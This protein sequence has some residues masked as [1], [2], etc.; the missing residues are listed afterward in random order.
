MDVDVPQGPPQGSPPL[1]EVDP[2]HRAPT[3][4]ALEINLSARVVKLLERLGVITSS[5]TP[6][7]DSPATK[8][9]ITDA[10]STT[11]WTPLI[12]LSDLVLL[13]SCIPAARLPAELP[14][15]IESASPTPATRSAL[16]DTLARLAL[17]PALMIE[18][19]TLFRPVAVVLV[20][21]WVEL[22]G[23]SEEGKW[24]EGEPGVEKAPGEKDAVEKVWIALVRA[25][26][27]MHDEVMPYL[28]LI[29][30]HPLLLPGPPL[31]ASTS[32]SFLPLLLTLHSAIYHLPSLPSVSEWSLPQAAEEVMKSHPHRGTR[33]VAWRI[34]RAW[35]GLYAGTGEELKKQWVW[36]LPVAS[37]SNADEEVLPFAPVVPYDSDYTTEYT[38]IFGPDAASPNDEADLL[39]SGSYSAELVSGTRTDDETVPTSRLVDGGLEV[40]VR[41]R[42]VDPWV[43]PMLEPVRA[44]E[45]R[46]RAAL[47]SNE[48]SSSFSAEGE[49]S[50]V[51][52]LPLGAL[53]EPAEFG[54]TVV[55]VA[56]AL[57]FRE[58]LIPSY[59]SASLAGAPSPV[60]SI[61]S[62]HAAAPSSTQATGP[63][64]EMFV[65]TSSHSALLA[66]LAGNVRRRVPTLVTGGPSSGKQSAV[67]HLWT[68]VHTAPS[69]TAL[70][71]EAKK[72]GLVVINLADRSLDSKSLLGSLSSAPSSSTSASTGSGAGQFTFIEGPLTRAV[73]QGR[74]LLL[75]NIDQAA[76]ELLSVVKVVAERMY[77]SAMQAKEGKSYG[78]I[79]AQ[80]ADG[81]VGVRVGGGEGRWVSA[82]EGFMLFATRSVPISSLPSTAEEEAPPATFFASH[83]FAPVLLPALS[84][85]EVAQIVQGRYGPQLDRVGGLSEL[86]VKSWEE[87]RD[88]NAQHKDGGKGG[89]KRDVGVRDLLRWCRRVAHLLPP[90]LALPSLASNPTL[91]EEVFVEARDVFLGSMVLPPAVSTPAITSVEDAA[92]ALSTDR[93]P[94]DRFSVLARSLA[95]SLGLSSERAEWCLRRRVP[96]LVLPTIDTSSGVAPSPSANLSVKVG[97]VSL[98]YLAPSTHSS[99]SRPYALTKPSLLAL[100]KLAVCLSLSEPV[101]LVGETGTGKTAAV[102]YLAELMGKKL[103]ALNLS[104]QTEAGDLVGG[105]RPIDEAEEARRSASEIVNRFVELFGA[106][107]SLS[108][109]GEFVSHV[110]KAFDKK[111]Y[112]RLV[113]LWR[114]AARMAS[115]RVSNDAPVTDAAEGDEQAQRKRRKVDSAKAALAER[116]KDFTTVVGDFEHRHVHAGGK[117]KAKF[118][119]SF[120]EGP[121]AQ[122][123]RNG[124]WVLLDEVNLASSETLESLSTLLQAPN[125]S[126]VL[127]EQGDLEPIP[128]HPEFRLFACMNPATDVGK[129]DLP[130][131]LRAKFSEIWVPPPDEDRDALRT[132]VEG[133][134]GRVAVSDRKVVDDV[135]TLYAVVKDLALRAQLADGQNMPPHFS[136]RTL[137]RALSFAS[138]FAP[139]FGLRR[140]LYEGFVMAFTML[141]D[142]RS[143]QVVRALIDKHVVQP[144]KNPRS[145]MERVPAM[146]SGME[147]AI[148]IHHYWLEEGPHDPEEP[149]DYILTS[150]VQ[151]KVCDLARAV[152]T[153]KVPVLIQGPTS[154]GKTSV[155]EYLAKRTGHRFVRINNHEHTDIQEY[156]GTYVSDPHSG[157]LVFQEGVLVR[158]LRRGDWIVLDELN[159]APTDVLEALNRLLDDNR[160]LVIPETGEVV[161][162]HPHF[163]LFATQNPPG[164]YGGRK[165]LSRAFRNRFLEMHF[166]DVPKDELKT[167]LERRCR[168]APSHAEKTVNVFLEL[169]RRRQAGRVFEQKQ[170]FAT[171]RDLFRW[172]GRGP[173]ETIQQL[174]EDGYMLLAER[175]RRADDKQTVKDVLEEVLKVKLDEKK[176]YDFERLPQLGLPVPSQ[177]AELVW[178]SAM[179]RL[180]FLIAAS[181]QRNEPVLLVGETGAGKTSVCQALALA[182]SSQ[183]HIVG[184]HQNTETADLLGGQRPLR[185]RAALQAALRKNAVELLEQQGRPTPLEEADIEDVLALIEALATEEKDEAAKTLAERIR[186]TTALFEWHDGPLV[187]AMRGGDLILLDEISLADD[188]V[189]ERLNSVLE[190]SRTLVL[191]EK[192]GHD[193][194]DIRVVGQE[195]FQILATMNP[196]GDFGKKELSPALRNRFTEIWVPAVDDLDD[197]LHIIGSRWAKAQREQ[198]EPFG[199]KILDFAKWL[200]QQ[201]GQGDG[202]GIGLRDILGWVDFLNVA[203]K[204]QGA[205][206]LVMADSFCQGA[207]MTVV[208]GL[209]ALPATSGLSKDGLDK[210]KSSCWRYLEQLVPTTM[211]PESLPLDVN[212]SEGVFSVGPF[213]VKKGDIPPAKVDYT[214]LAPTTRL[215]AMRLL[216]ALQLSKP[217]LL[218]GSPGVGKTSLVTALSAATGHSLV[219]INLSDQTDLMDL[220][221]SDLPVE[222]GKSGEFAWKDA[223]FLAAMQKGEWV[224]LD[225]M[226]LASQSVLEGLNSCLDHR[227]AVYIPELDRTFNRHPDFRIFAAQN[228]LGQGGGR[229]GLPKSFLD[230]FSLVHMEELDAIDLNAIAAALYPDMDAAILSKMIAFNSTVHRQTMEQRAFGMEGSP[231]EFNLRDVLRWLTLVRSSSGLDTRQ[232]EAIEYIRLLYLQRFRDSADREHVA[233]L[234]ASS[235]GE[236]VDPVERPWP[237]L[238]SSHAQ[239]GHSL[240]PRAD[241]SLSSQR[242]SASLSLQQHSLQPLEALTKCLDMGWL[243]ILTGPR[244]T[245]KTA[246]IRQVAALGGR[247]LREFTMNA[248]VDTL[249]LLGSFEQADRF[250]ELDSLAGDAVTLLE[251][252]AAGQLRVDGSSTVHAQLDG[253]RRIRSRITAEAAELEVAA[254]GQAIRH[255]FEAIPAVDS[256]R[257]D[258]LSAKIDIAVS[259]ADAATG[260]ARFEWVDGPLVQAMKNG[261]WLLIEDANL[262]SPSVL[263]RLNSLFETGGRLQLAERGPVN[264]EIQIIAPHPD[265]RLV[266]TLDPR[267]GEL[268]RAMRNRG[269]EIAVLSPPS[270][271]AGPGFSADEFRDPTFSPLARL[272]HL[273]SL[274]ASAVSPAA[275]VQQIG[276]TLSPSHFP[277]ALRVLRTF[278][279]ADSTSTEYVLRQLGQHA[280]VGHSIGAKKALAQT[281]EVPLNLLTVQPL[282][283]SLV[284]LAAALERNVAAPLSQA[285]SSLLETLTFLLLS[286]TS[287]PRG[288][289]RSAAKPVRHLA[290]WDRSLLAAHGK[291]KLEEVESV[292]AG[293]FPL[294]TALGGLVGRLAGFQLDELEES[295][296]LALTRSAKSL[297]TLARELEAVSDSADLDFSTVQHV[298]AWVEEA[299]RQLPPACA[300]VAEEAQQRLAPLRSSLTLTSGKA[301]E[302][303]WKAS[304]PY[305]HSNPAL[306]EVYT[307]L[308]ERGR[309]SVG[310]RWENALSNLFLEISV[311]LGVPQVAQ[312]QL[313]NAA[314]HIVEQLLERIPPSDPSDSDDSVIALADG[315]N[316]A[317]LLVAE[318]A[319]VSTALLGRSAI[320]PAG[321]L[322]KIVQGSGVIPLADA[323]ALHQLA[324]WPDKNLDSKPAAVFATLLHWAEHLA[325]GAAKAP[326]ATFPIDIVRPMLLKKVVELRSGETPTLG[327]LVTQSRALARTAALQLAAS[328]TDS[329]SRVEG[330][331][332]ALVALIGLVVGSAG[333]DEEPLSTNN[334]VEAV[335]ARAASVASLSEAHERYLAK[336][337][338][339]LQ[340]KQVPLPAVASGLVAFARFLWHLY[341]P[342]LP[343]DPAV[344][345]RAHSGFLAR[346][347][348]AMSEV[349]AAVQLD[350]RALTGNSSNAKLGRVQHEVD[351]LRKQLEQAGVAPVVREGNPALLNALFAELRSFQEQIV[352]DVQLDSL[353]KAFE[354]PWSQA[355]ASREANLQ[356][357]IDTLLRRLDVAYNESTDI[358]API[359][360][361][362]ALFKI[363][364]ALLTHVAQVAAAPAS[365][366]AFRTLARRL[367]GFPSIAYLPAVHED[368]LPLTIKV[369]E[370]PLHPAQATLLQVAALTSS[371]ADETLSTARSAVRLTQLYERLHYLY[372]TDRRH[373][374]EAAEAAAS[375]YKAKVDVQQVATDE[376]LEAA[377]FAK[378]FPSFEGDAADKEDDPMGAHAS[379]KARLVQ[380]SDQHLLAKLHVGL[381]GERNTGFA[382]QASA[383][384]KRLRESGVA[385]LLPRLYESLD[386]S[387]D[388]DSAAFRVRALVELSQ[389]VNPPEQVEA[390]HHDFYNEPNVRETA[391]AVPVLLGFIDRLTDLVAKWPDQV[392]LHSL[393]DRC[394]AILALTADAS[395]ALVLTNLEQ[396]LQQSEDWEKYA[397][398]E[399]S[400]STNRNALIALIVEWR[401]FELTCWSRLLTTVEVKF[402]ESAADWWFRFYEAAIRGAPGVDREA[403]AAEDPEAFYRDL[404]TLLDSFITSSSVGQFATRLDLVVSFAN[405]AATLGGRPDAEEELGAGAASLKRVAALLYN[406]HAFYSQF[407]TR[408]STF[409]TS[410][411][412]RVE[413]EVQNVIKLASWKDVNVFALRASAVRSHHQLYK[414]V[415]KLRTLLQKPASDQFS[416]DNVEKISASTP[417][418]LPPFLTAS[419]DLPPLPATVDTANDASHLVKLDQTLSRLNK[420]AASTVGDLVGAGH[421]AG[422]EEFAVQI[423]ST[424]KDLREE[425]LGAEEGREQRVKNLI[426]R[427]RRAWRDLLNELKR[428]GISPS[429][430]PK[431]V[432][433]LEDVGAVYSLSPSAPLLSLDE[434]VFGGDSRQRVVKADSYHYRMLSE[435]PTLRGYPAAHNADVRT[436]DVQRA[437]GHINSGINY[438]FDQRAQLLAASMAQVQLDLFVKRFEAVKAEQPAL[439]IRQL[440][441]VLL[442]TVSEVVQALIETRDELV[443]FR[444]ATQDSIGLEATLASNTVI[445]SL[446]TLSRDQD[447][448][449]DAVAS[450]AY[451]DPVLAMPE[452]FTFAQQTRQHLL[453]TV[454][455]FTDL[456]VPPSLRY[457]LVPL[458]NYLTD[459]DIPSLGGSASSKQDVQS[460]KAAHDDLVSAVLIVAQELKKLADEGVKVVEE[461]ELVDGAVGVAGKS[462]RGVL[463]AFRL[464]EMLAKVA[465]FARRAHASLAQGSTAVTLVTRVAPFLRLYSELFS[466]HLSSFFDWHKSSLKLNH[467]LASILK[468][469]AAEGFCR[470]PEGDT[471]N[472]ADADTSDGKT[473]EGTGMAEGTGAKNVSNE[474]EDE[475]QLEGLQS[476][477]PQEKREDEQQEEGDDDAVEMQQD[478]D[479]EMEDRG[480]GAKDEQDEGESDDEDEEKEDPEEQVADVDPLDPS[481]VD[482][483]FWGDD[484]PPQ[485]NKEGQTDEVNQETTKSAGEAEMSAKEDQQAAPQ[486]KGEEGAE[487]EK[488][489]EQAGKEE[490]KGQEGAEK[491]E[492]EEQDGEAGEE[493]GGEGVEQGEEEENGDDG[494]Q[495]PPQTGEQLDS[496]MPEGENLDL[497]DDMNLDGDEKDKDADGDEDLDL[498]DEMDMPEDGPEGEG[499]DD[500]R[501]D[502]VDEMGDAKE[503]GAEE[504]EE[505]PLA[506]NDTSAQPEGEDEEDTKAEDALDQ[507]FGGADQGETGGEGE[508]DSAASKPDSASAA[509]VSRQA[510]AQTAAQETSEPNAQ[511]EAG[512]EDVDAEME[513]DQ[514]DNLA[515][516]APSAT[517]T[518]PSKQRA[519]ADPSADP[520]AQPQPQQDRS[521]AEPQRSLGDALQNWRRRLEAIGDLAQPEDKPEGAAPEPQQD[522]AVEYV[523]EGDEQDVDEQALGPAS[524]E[525]VKKLEQLHIGEEVAPPEDFPQDQEMDAADQPDQPAQQQAQTMQLK[526][527][528]LTEADAKA[529]PA[530]ELRQDRSIAEE[531]REMEDEVRAEDDQHASTTFAPPIDPQED[532]AVEQALLK[533]RA[534]DDPNM[535]SEGVW[536]LYESLTR[537]LSFALTEQLRLILEPTL[538]TRLKGDY[539]SGKRLN[540]KKIIPYI[541]SEFTKDKIWLRR[542]RPSQREYQ[543]LIAIDDSKSM[544]DSHSVHLAFQSLALISRALTRL[545]VGGVSICRFGESMD[546]LHPFEAG[547]VS[548]EAGANLLSKFT[549]QQT[550][551]DVR[552]LVERSLAHLAA[553]KESAASGKSSLSAGDLWQLQVIISDG[554]CQ[555][556]DRLRALLRQA[557]EQKVMFVFVVIDSLHRRTEEAS[558]AAAADQNQHSILA[559]KSVSYV[560]NAQGRLEL[561]MDRYLDSFPFEYFVVLRDVEAL[562]EVLSATLRQF[563]ERVS[564]DR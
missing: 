65:S 375:L 465:T 529:I 253:L 385:T 550:T 100:E 194:D 366:V 23:L 334:L 286:P 346:Q 1:I 59:T 376:E 333:E 112:S 105:F 394:Q 354:Q 266:M 323:V 279:F 350:E 447:R 358:V 160:E 173:V 284:P 211:P 77:T 340:Q 468:E 153:R 381:F 474:I 24:R 46:Q 234:F 360:L 484:E 351:L 92:T 200:A 372:A 423:I 201:I 103:T 396:L 62:T 228:P 349:L 70:T 545:E 438:A 257:A 93:L 539:R 150:S 308:M 90:T 563:F 426:E 508:Q 339:P 481:S 510:G 341:V 224:L 245:G 181:L 512:A 163:M 558:N 167:I 500:E 48:L 141:L 507:S 22:L 133:Y 533:W 250:R 220:L 336:A 320:L 374:E 261:D 102:G 540:M 281:R 246:L 520:N 205:S 260:A 370:T 148:R 144:A 2:P 461:E 525:Q 457:L 111:R 527:S 178:T 38:S 292:I 252:A 55:A 69:S 452:E 121:L 547:V 221:G 387:L 269:I 50:H 439:S 304:L 562:P 180:Y 436:P 362:L 197:L 139:T 365:Q 239:I 414:C 157:K 116:W 379:N 293:L 353:A 209:G 330:L 499:E 287:Q 18:I 124:D 165:V 502:Q 263:D 309:N 169:Q 238:S 146:P 352:G 227:G 314:V 241:F 390:P 40:L 434:V 530:T 324:S 158:A 317:S 475:S 97:R 75:L 255:G 282:D 290:V 94:R 410:E 509:D 424:A 548:D 462:Y 67:S 398:R 192:G 191:A 556:H 504:D 242:A 177:N 223:P 237:S 427:K 419:G 270:H 498:G 514:Q 215:N 329:S 172:G 204:Q 523:Q 495:A 305:K 214:L 440:F 391:K 344:G 188:S 127:T 332:A 485:E 555:D 199:V 240:L 559:M 521:P 57:A 87:V 86:L 5:S 27:L 399:H 371:I 42:G 186:A 369:G 432:A 318:L 273:A 476:D 541:A 342:N 140:A 138:D 295:D 259:T 490:E 487:E 402:G 10:Y 368:E 278:S 473:T 430:S 162:P 355:T 134:I 377:E 80:E 243:A 488:K 128:R 554:M 68:L 463:K 74:W 41:L 283:S 136:M 364:F 486:P 316:A 425:P 557:A 294:F 9:V 389:T 506:G 417:T 104:N 198:L 185:N 400:I 493:E 37:T 126:L 73:R 233:R 202:L 478:F 210:L 203:A 118:V 33:Y 433:R 125:S 382:S 109:N 99:T 455:S 338:P 445:D 411:R 534:G 313:D 120:V 448:L 383:V 404:V 331:R 516:S 416:V 195:G 207:L 267:N 117:G 392:V 312:Q 119:F 13:L 47:S 532:K 428:I 289:R 328:T 335:S 258:Q 155:V 225:E 34:V 217:V 19:I 135:A 306:A 56:G 8:S 449:R 441:D 524:E 219:R 222:G 422:L 131:G 166:G 298:V 549:F 291:L 174:A 542:T 147:R 248:E 543:V 538:A 408:I 300:A 15:A 53:T 251:E 453:E 154:A 54:K 405:Y 235:F 20:G 472:G 76:P 247:R 254:V 244:G 130:V 345:L 83:F 182:L 101:L 6:T 175:A 403:P 418:A 272:A 58:G 60:A 466:R 536:R 236:Y 216:R 193:L 420:L 406:V 32:P 511:R 190:P 297:Q 149:E 81:G 535:T 61:S 230:R 115:S 16:L 517:G 515:P 152:L 151:A 78:G 322:V 395:I 347:L 143:Q 44:K 171:L 299:F 518:G 464:E 4:S 274:P 480:D 501:P 285:A 89:S 489:E 179:R 11:Q 229:K 122:A 132:I 31:P 363:G 483:K 564:S 156:V 232:H 401:R 129:R 88:L 277:L 142:E 189:L 271:D 113:G 561:K 443:N 52:E 315:A 218:E 302:A 213:G 435:L 337:L 184:C 437:L 85:A 310:E 553:A 208:D 29:L 36:Q 51:E 275:L 526:G 108:R 107:F 326:T 348:A 95:L 176:L 91:Q 303:I 491:Q 552:L 206:S 64:A 145:L 560:H 25:L 35:L 460:L 505:N 388:R 123:I 311:A 397:D 63:Q 30:R 471:K 45:E 39:P 503:D 49:V 7:E 168:I 256:T 431:I 43:L 3:T 187:Q 459:V 359:R 170:A 321:I 384:L 84:S 531:D 450:F 546:V 161:T 412:A 226:N 307:R 79:G 519:A 492:G 357:S 137:A 21:R 196:G 456:S 451:F 343:L 28:R 378:L 268:S 454:Q 467:V 415:R 513:D 393:K 413:K 477:V 296:R 458:T 249:E 26:P 537:D 367:T 407:S 551:T 429:P 280:L 528:T 522:G 469:L 98:P 444:A 72:R 114:E 421:G 325:R 264:G 17:E 496:Q 183:L 106:T 319:A 96:E 231:W 479:G 494:D 14:F 212:E 442:R 276:S 409:L 386:E 470:P 482:E 159:L 446:A 373:D 544:A 262:C 361:T 265:F 301:M 66:S 327:N 288:V 164:L 380:P 110:R 71:T 82:G 356:R 497:P 12:P